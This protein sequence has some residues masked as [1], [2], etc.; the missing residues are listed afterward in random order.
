MQALFYFNAINFFT[1]KL[2]DDCPIIEK[3]PGHPTPAAYCLYEITLREFCCS[4]HIVSKCGRRFSPK[5]SL[6]RS[7]YES[8]MCNEQ[9]SQQVIS[10]R[11][12]AAG[13][14]CP[15]AFNNN[16]SL[17]PL[18]ASNPEFEFIQCFLIRILTF[19]MNQIDQSGMWFIFV[20]IIN[21]RRIKSQ[22]E[23]QMIHVFSGHG[24]LIQHLDRCLQTVAV[25]CLR[26]QINRH[27][28]H[29]IS[30]AVADQNIID[31]FLCY[32]LMQVTVKVI[33]PSTP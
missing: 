31:A 2:R 14:E 5:V 10:Y 32:P 25:L 21:V 6:R 12:Y 18:Q 4:L 29:D 28:A 30:G 8:D 19:Q 16:I 33:L 7:I 11:Q 26:I 17:R 13:M 15:G 27:T 1:L 3:A 23:P 20:F 24:I 9:K 22:S